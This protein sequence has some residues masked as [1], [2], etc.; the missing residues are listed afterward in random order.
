MAKTKITSTA[1]SG[2]SDEVELSPIP[3]VLVLNSGHKG[4]AASIEQPSVS[5]PKTFV[6][7]KIHSAFYTTTWGGGDFKPFQEPIV[8]PRTTLFFSTSSATNLRPPIAVRQFLSVCS[9]VLTLSVPAVWGAWALCVTRT[10]WWREATLLFDWI[11][12]PGPGAT[13]WCIV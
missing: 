1:I 11:F 9:I 5:T 10:S 13:F 12:R 8:R 4:S 6:V 2:P 7:G 3:P